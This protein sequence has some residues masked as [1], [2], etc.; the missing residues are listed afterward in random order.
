MLAN[1]NIDNLRSAWNLC[2]NNLDIGNDFIAS[3]LSSKI[4]AI[5]NFQESLPDVSQSLGQLLNAA[6]DNA[7][8]LY[9]K[10]INCDN[11]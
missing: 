7:K 2:V 10:K 4:T 3:S 6:T 11:E 5:I 1:I 9:L 8:H